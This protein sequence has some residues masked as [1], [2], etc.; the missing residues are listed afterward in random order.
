MISLDKKQPEPLNL[1]TLTLKQYIEPWPKYKVLYDP[2]TDTQKAHL[3]LNAKKIEVAYNL[4]SDYCS[5]WN[6]YV[7]N[8]ILNQRKFFYFK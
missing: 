7:P 5:F 3:V 1:T 4:R 2:E 8:L 6:S